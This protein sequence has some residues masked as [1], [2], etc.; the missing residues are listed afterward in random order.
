MATSQAFLSEGAPPPPPPPVAPGAPPPPSSA[1]A[2]PPALPAA[3][4]PPVAATPA[5]A[6]GVAVPSVGFLRA[7]GKELSNQLMSADS[8][9]EALARDLRKVTVDARAGLQQRIDVLDGRLVQL[10]KDIAENGRLLAVAGGGS[11]STVPGTGDNAPYGLSPGNVTAM[12]IVFTLFVLF[13][14]ALS[15]SRLLWRRAT[16]TA[17]PPNEP[18][19]RLERVEQAVDAIA[20]EIERISEGQRFVTQ[21]M[22]H[23]EPPVALGVGNAASAPLRAQLGHTVMAGAVGR[24]SQR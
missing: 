18:D 4:Q 24:D 19:P 1:Q 12:S 14:L 16:R 17:R 2:A 10:E 3:P 22:T 15:A 21:L 8:R 7:R 20:V 6:V 13:P 23:A 11:G 9:R 5:P